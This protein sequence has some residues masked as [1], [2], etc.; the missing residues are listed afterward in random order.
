ML[1]VCSKGLSMGHSPSLLQDAP[2]VE[3]GSVRVES[4]LIATDT[5]MVSLSVGMEAMSLDV[6]VHMFVTT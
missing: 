2:P 1:T 3:S 6:E 4:V 5:V